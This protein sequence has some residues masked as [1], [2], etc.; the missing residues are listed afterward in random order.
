MSPPPNT[1]GVIITVE[2][3]FNELSKL[4]QVE[5]IALGG[6]RAGIHYDEKSD[7]DIYLYCT[8]PISEE[9]TRKVQQIAKDVFKAL[10]LKKYARMDFML[11]AQGNAYCL[12]A[13]TLPG[14]TPTS[15]IPQE[16]AA[17]GIGY[18]Q[19]CQKIIDMAFED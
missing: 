9:E 15:L 17:A 4:P 13:N 6:S 2:Q 10:R 14:M 7:Y 18:D 16:A 19:L 8:A 5:A 1:Q 12:E 3:F 11:D